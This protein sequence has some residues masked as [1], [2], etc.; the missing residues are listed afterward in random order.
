MEK[1]KK[2]EISEEMVVLAKQR[3]KGMKGGDKSRDN[4]VGALGV[5]GTEL[6][7]PGCQFVD[8]RNYDLIYKGKNLEVKT[9]SIYPNTI[10]GPDLEF[11]I[12]KKTPLQ[13]CDF[14]VCLGVDTKFESMWMFGVMPRETVHSSNMIGRGLSFADIDEL[15][16]DNHLL[17][18]KQMYPPEY[19]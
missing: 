13:W 19:I 1:Y 5:I 4:V 12:P 11:L 10:I 6:Y 18:L 14:Y 16:E 7:Y 15:K 8:K 2:C 17:Y 3:C 9:R